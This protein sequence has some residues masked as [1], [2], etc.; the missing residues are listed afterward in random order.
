[1]AEDI[2][3]RRR[4]HKNR[5]LQSGGVL[6]VAQARRMIKVR[7]DDEL[8]KA[9]RVVQ[10]A[11]QRAH[12]K[13]KRVRA[14][15]T[16]LLQEL[17]DLRKGE[18]SERPLIFV[19]H[20][21]G[22]IIV[23]EALRLAKYNPT[24][25]PG[26]DSSA[27]SLIFFGC[28]H[29][30][31]EQQIMEESMLRLILH[32]SKRQMP[33]STIIR[34]AK[35]LSEAV[36]EVN[37][38]FLHARILIQRTVVNIFSEVRF[39]IPFPHSA[40]PY[41]PRL[42]H[43]YRNKLQRALI[44][45]NWVNQPK[46]SLL[47]LYGHRNITEAAQYAFCKLDATRRS[48][49]V[50]GEHVLHFK[51]DSHDV[52]RK[53]VGDMARVFMNAILIYRN[54]MNGTM[55]N[56]LKPPPFS[57]Y[58]HDEDA[59]AP[60][61]MVRKAAGSSWQGIYIID[62]LDEC[63]ES[64]SLILAE[65]LRAVRCSEQ[66]FKVLVTS[67]SGRN[68]DI[69]DALSDQFT[70]D[71]DQAYDASAGRF[72]PEFDSEHLHLV[73]SLLQSRPKFPVEQSR[74][75]IDDLLS[76]CQPDILLRRQ[77]AEWLRMTSHISSQ[78]CLAREVERLS[79]P[80]PERLYRRIVEEI[81][82]R[83][84]S[85]ALLVL[86][87]ALHSFRPLRPQELGIALSLSEETEG[88][89]WI[90]ATVAELENSELATQIADCFGPMVG[91]VNSE[92][93]FNGSCARRFLSDYF[94]SSAKMS[95]AD[96]HRHLAEACCRYFT[97]PE[98]R[99]RLEGFSQKE[100]QGEPEG[101][102][103]DMEDFFPYAMRFLPGHHD[104]A[105]ALAEQPGEEQRI[106][107]PFSPAVPSYIMAFYRKNPEFGYYS[108]GKHVQEDGRYFIVRKDLEPEFGSNESALKAALIAAA[109]SGKAAIVTDIVT[110]MANNGVPGSDWP[111]GPLCRL[112]WL[113][114][115]DL[116]QL[117]LDAGASADVT[118]GREGLYEGW[119]PLD[120]AVA[121]NHVQLVELLLQHTDLQSED[122][123]RKSHLVKTASKAGYHEV[124]AILIQHGADVSH[125][126]QDGTT[127]SPLRPAASRRHFMVVRELIVAGA[128]KDLAESNAGQGLSLAALAG[129]MRCVEALLDLGV[130]VETKHDNY[131]TALSCAACYG[132]ADTCR[133]LLDRGAS[134]E[135]T[136][137]CCSIIAHAAN[138]GSL[139]V[140]KLLLEEAGTNIDTAVN[141]QTALITATQDEFATSRDI[142][143]YL[144]EKGADVN[145]ASEGSNTALSLAAE[146]GSTELV[147]LLIAAGAKVNVI[148]DERKWSPL[149]GGLPFADVTRALLE[150]GA[151]I[152]A[153]SN[154][155]TPLYWAAFCNHIDTVRELLKI[156]ANLE[157]VYKAPGE[158]FVDDGYTALRAAVAN[159]QPVVTRLLLEAGADV[160]A[161][162]ASDGSGPLHAAVA[163]GDE[164]LVELLLQYNVDMEMKDDLGYTPLH[165][166]TSNTPVSLV[167]RLVK[168]GGDLEA[169]SNSKFNPLCRAVYEG[170]FAV[171]E[172]FI[173]KGVNLGVP[174]PN[175]GSPLHI[176]CRFSTLEI[177]NL[178]LRNGADVDFIDPEQPG[179]PLMTTCLYLG[180]KPNNKNLK[181]I[182][183]YF[184]GEGNADINITGGIYGTALHVACLWGDPGM[185]RLLLDKGADTITTADEIGRHPLHLA[186]LRTTEHI[187]VLLER[188]GDVL[189]RDKMGRTVLHAAVSSGRVEVVEKL[190]PLI[191][192]GV[193][194]KDNDGWTPLVWAAK[195][196]G[197]AYG[198]QRDGQLAVIET[199]LKAGADPSLTGEGIRRTWTQLEVA[200]Y[201]DAGDDVVALLS[202]E[203]K[204]DPRR[205]R[206]HMKKGIKP[207]SNPWC[208][209]CMLPLWG[210]YYH[211]QNCEDFDLCFKCYRSKNTIH[212]D[213]TFVER[214][215]EVIVG[216][217][218]EEPGDAQNSEPAE[219]EGEAGEDNAEH[220][221]E[222][223]DSD[224]SW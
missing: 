142:A 222:D 206:F 117:L 49:W 105:F 102:F 76:S 114:M 93:Q 45:E 90:P 179:T 122:V 27:I 18:K 48:P 95:G 166:L 185:I 199:L 7:E 72:G 31:A 74:T 220:G 223:S 3:N 119:R 190:L 125:V 191:S 51:F 103:L 178:L 194:A 41:A 63:D 188:G 147:R 156:K 16:R 2:A 224:D 204:E 169:R 203:P 42:N 164:E 210:E 115:H 149:H 128:G 36:T 127:I 162:L 65:F 67:T 221:N 212:V 14:E 186:A 83:R 70:I 57:D 39:G 151:D 1:M 184:L 4:L 202:P 143:R 215:D 21:I 195:P 110:H 132:H 68:Q 155:G 167:A 106:P 66:R 171:A 123:L 54:H 173:K 207:N 5:P 201:H 24:R 71:A 121:R 118:F 124:L 81:P 99:H 154:D 135:N 136:E 9:R 141:N 113:G 86:T 52:R 140:V 139:E 138:S 158:G 38:G 79:P 89:S 30:F 197:G 8:A 47:H 213:H 172:Y 29:R 98:V 183:D 163:I 159:H 144:I 153:V 181:D 160:N 87:W 200:V 133:L 26:I 62:G 192:D 152:E 53:S 75:K 146:N 120:F 129:H 174:V 85:F 82:P 100:P 73:E 126:P 193:N 17:V 61:N 182:L 94:Y 46:S 130:P 112:S 107:A 34:R 219:G 84:L 19:A 101:L 168:R 78:A 189:A 25:F 6:I 109:G 13:I 50:M 88:E 55:G 33:S 108:F 217:D 40:L 176:A 150:N 69:K 20:D 175:Y 59:W 157:Y 15:A 10:A 12:N 209:A 32:A 43:I 92:L 137:G 218:E 80:S 116:V 104:L 161:K 187:D 56:D 208:D 35:D 96:C 91:F 131:G 180:A 11:K 60:F 134:T 216:H 205:Q 148:V 64:R 198:T 23:K 111:R 37:N 145:T 97:I 211:C 77:V 22:G 165:K 170:N 44:Y 177:V 58:W 196:N 28:S 214:G